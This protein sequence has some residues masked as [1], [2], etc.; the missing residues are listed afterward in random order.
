MTPRDFH[1]SSH[2]GHVKAARLFSNIVSPPV[3]FAVLGVAFGLYEDPSL[4]GFGWAAVYGLLVSL[5]P[6]LVV[7]YF[8]KTGRIKELH[9]TNKGERHLPYLSAVFFA[10][11]ALVIITYFNGP[12]LLRCLTIFNAIELTALGVINTRWLISLHSTG[13]MATFLLVGLV[14]GW[15][16]AIIL[17]LPFVFAVCF[18]RLYLNRHTPAQVIAGLLLGV[19]SVWI[20]TL[21]GC[22]V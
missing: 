20:M 3:M 1:K 2:T 12:E 15:T 10:L 8:L 19:F 17:I 16:A 7:L 18:V 14:F 4:I 22:F 6:I 5:A 9:M 13:I 11:L 21:M